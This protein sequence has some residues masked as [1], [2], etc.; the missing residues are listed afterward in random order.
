MRNDEKLNVI[1]AGDVL[2][3]RDPSRK[4][5]ATPITPT[6]ACGP[7]RMPHRHAAVSA[8]PAPAPTMHYAL[9]V[10]LTWLLG[11]FALPLTPAGRGHRRWL[12]LGV[13][14]GAAGL[15]VAIVPY[16]RFVP[17][18]NLATPLA[19]G[20][21]AALAVFGGFSAWARAVLLAA[22]HVP[23]AHR[24]P[25]WCRSRAA[26]AALGLVAP[27][28]GMLAGGSR[29]RAGL[30]LWALWPAAL[31]LL[32]IRNAPGMWR[33]LLSTQPDRAAADLLE[34][35]LLLSAAGVGLG[36]LAWL[37]QALEGARRLAPAPALARGRGDWFAVALGV[38][39]LALAAGGNPGLAARHL[40]DAASVLQAEGLSIIP[41]QL[42]LAAARLD[43]GSAE[44]AVVAIGLH[45]VRGD[46]QRAQAVRERLD[47]GLAPYVALLAAPAPGG[48][49][50]PAGS[51]REVDPA[52]AGSPELYYGTLARA[53]RAAGR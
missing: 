47:H 21:L 17:V 27:G 35:W 12:A 20:S 40:G 2:D 14:S 49:A 24:L 42:S 53:R 22:A 1:E 43:P 48:G 7:Y 11:P 23:P 41:L 3:I 30:W 33:H 26:V 18:T 29:W 13:A 34:G 5:V 9:L 16:E 25:R 6:P 44:Y 38:S 46:A 19:W 10:A 50:T 28:C 8:A 31:G 36:A 4:Q 37:V 32:V 52:P 39:C 51:L 15:V 45:E